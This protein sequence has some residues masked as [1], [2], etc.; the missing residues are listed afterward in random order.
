MTEDRQALLQHLADRLSAIKRTLEA[1][2]TERRTANTEDANE[3][4]KLHWEATEGQREAQ[5]PSM[6]V[7]VSGIEDPGELY[8]IAGKQIEAEHGK[9]GK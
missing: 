9:G 8:G 1:K 5:A 2:I 7:D 4:Y 3:L 6:D